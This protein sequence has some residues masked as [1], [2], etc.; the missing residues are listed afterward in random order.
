M[1]VTFDVIFIAA[2]S[3]RILGKNGRSVTL[4]AWSVIGERNNLN[5]STQ[6]IPL[7][8]KTKEATAYLAQ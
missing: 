3:S 6:T 5:D 1:L 4:Q 2:S 7:A 8:L